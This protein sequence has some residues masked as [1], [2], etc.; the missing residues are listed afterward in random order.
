MHRKNKKRG[1]INEYHKFRSEK[2]IISTLCEIMSCRCELCFWGM[3]ND[4]SLK[5][6]NYCAIKNV[7]RK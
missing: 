5:M 4:A 7:Q 1:I 2:T 6:I 3:K